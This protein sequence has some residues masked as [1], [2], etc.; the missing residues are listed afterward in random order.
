MKN[1]NKKLVVG[2]P[3]GSLQEATIDLFNKAGIE[4]KVSSRSYYPSINDSEI[5]V[6]MVRAQEMARY[7]EDGVID[8]GFTGND[9]VQECNAK[10]TEIVELVYAKQSMNKV[11]WV[12]A[13][14]EN[15]KINSAKDLNRKI[16]ATE[17]V[18]VTKKWLKK[19][20]VKAKVEFSW[21]AT[22][23]KCPYLA[24]A[25]VELTE[26]GST[27]RKNNLR[28]VD[29]IMESS[30]RMIANKNALKNKWKK[31][32]IEFIKILLEAVLE[33]KKRVLLEMNV[34]KKNFKKLISILPAMKYPTISPLYQEQGYAV[35]IA[36]E[37]SFVPKLIPKIKKYGGTDILEYELLKVIK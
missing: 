13:V 22:E 34:N 35:K 33:A 16:I 26:T 36:V 28:I 32:K 23:T 24:D 11:K 25:I 14:P 6:I 8:V 19:N 18:N 37:K 20:K 7:V 12:L 17:L 29:T 2:I 1:E 10:V 3:K 27:L 9:W 31:E 5:D 4:I 15:S 21:G 30:T